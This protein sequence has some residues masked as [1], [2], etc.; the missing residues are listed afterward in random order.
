MVAP[1]VFASLPMSAFA[2]E[3]F[4]GVA[5]EQRYNDEGSTENNKNGS[6]ESEHGVAWLMVE[7]DG[8][9]LWAQRSQWKKI[10]ESLRRV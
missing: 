8:F 10:R 3:L 4:K 7:R 5:K 6:V 1:G 9:T 2:G